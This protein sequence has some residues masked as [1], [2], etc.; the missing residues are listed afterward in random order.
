MSAGTD[1]SP[2]GEAGA[3]WG[4]STPPSEGG[5]P[6]GL[7]SECSSND[8][9]VFCPQYQGTQPHS[10]NPAPQALGK[11][12]VEKLTIKVHTLV[13][14]LTNIFSHSEGCLFV[15]FM[16][17]FPVQ[18]LLSFIRSRLLIYDFISI[19]LG[20]GSKKMLL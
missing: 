17:F 16:V 6:S 13:A 1:P 3:E 20:G 2:G 15:L 9:V 8:G 5:L 11:F 19:T 12:P 10:P 18:K 7:T 14:S 4:W